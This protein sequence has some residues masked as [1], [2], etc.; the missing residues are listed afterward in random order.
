MKTCCDHHASELP[1]GCQ[2]G[3]KCPERQ[4]AEERIAADPVGVEAALPITPPTG[5]ADAPVS[6]TPFF[7]VAVAL[8]GAIAAYLYVVFGQIIRG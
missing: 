5:W 1:D 8:I 6:W 2:Q 4:S 7:G 3:R